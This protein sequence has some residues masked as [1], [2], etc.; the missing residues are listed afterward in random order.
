[1]NDTDRENNSREMSATL[2]LVGGLSVLLALQITTAIAKMNGIP[3]ENAIAL[4]IQAVGITTAGITLADLAINGK[5]TTLS[6]GWVAGAF[7]T[8]AGLGRIF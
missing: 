2:L 5:L 4:V 8:S 7:V 1:M 3:Q 6:I